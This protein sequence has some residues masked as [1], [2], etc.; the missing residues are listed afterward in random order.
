MSRTVNVDIKR[1]L[2]F[3]R[4][5]SFTNTQGDLCKALLRTTKI[6]IFQ[7]YTEEL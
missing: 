7:H 1:G 6:L 4:A 3:D 2:D 5:I